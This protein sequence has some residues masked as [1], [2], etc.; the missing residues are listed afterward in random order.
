MYILRIR[1]W[2][3]F[4]IVLPAA[5]QIIY[6][7]QN[8]WSVPKVLTSGNRYGAHPAHQRSQAASQ[9]RLGV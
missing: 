1:I 5:I 4:P 7:V 9:V 8:T 3:V 2:L 6:I